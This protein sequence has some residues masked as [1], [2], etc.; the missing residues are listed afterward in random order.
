[1]SN[2]LMTNRTLEHKLFIGYWIFENWKLL[3][4][5]CV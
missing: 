3:S 4:G 1:M 2:F 5:G